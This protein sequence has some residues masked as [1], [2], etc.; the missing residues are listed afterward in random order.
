MTSELPAAALLTAATEPGAT[1]KTIMLR[2]GADGLA[3]AAQIP[4]LMAAVDQHA[5]AV[6]ESLAS[7]GLPVTAVPLASYGSAVLAAAAR[8][9]WQPPDAADLD[10]SR[11]TWF[12]LRLTAVCA[13]AIAY[14]Y[15]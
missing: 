14:D 12:H 3:A 6:R 11:A 1:L 15:L 10:W 8:M 7:R 13:L 9:G 4:S 5:A 2:T